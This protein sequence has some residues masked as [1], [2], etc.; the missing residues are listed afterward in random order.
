MSAHHRIQKNSIA[1]LMPAASGGRIDHRQSIVSSDGASDALLTM[2]NAPRA[3]AAIAYAYGRNAHRL[4]AAGRIRRSTNAAMP[5]DKRTPM[6]H[7]TQAWVALRSRTAARPQSVQAMA[8]AARR[9]ANTTPAAANNTGLTSV[10]A[11][12]AAAP[13]PWRRTFEAVITARIAV[14]VSVFV[15]N[16]EVSRRSVR[17][18]LTKSV[19][20]VA[21]SKVG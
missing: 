9:P 1:A 15:P 13:V 4:R 3:A 5:A 16:S 6:P 19:E 12:L 7:T 10:S 2:T 14:L 20:F 11:T 18:H 21:S 17:A 8:A